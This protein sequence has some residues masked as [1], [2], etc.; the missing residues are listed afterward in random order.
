MEVDLGVIAALATAIVGLITFFT[1]RQQINNDR[2]NVEVWRNNTDRDAKDL[3]ERVSKLE[4]LLEKIT[5][6]KLDPKFIQNGE[7]KD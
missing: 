7:I 1:W 3:A 2:C 6:T 4:G 5:V